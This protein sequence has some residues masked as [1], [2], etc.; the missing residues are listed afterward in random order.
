MPD[1]PVTPEPSAERPSFSVVTTLFDK[2]EY[3]AECLDS[4]AAQADSDLEHVVVDDGSTDGSVGVV[5]RFVAEGHGHVR[6]LR[7]DRRGCG[8][9]GWRSWGS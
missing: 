3:V 1:Q 7:T 6:L 4:V 2:A 5:E 9:C 8:C